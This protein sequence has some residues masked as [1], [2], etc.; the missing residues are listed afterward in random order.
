MIELMLLGAS[1]WDSRALCPGIGLYLYEFRP[2]VSFAHS[3]AHSCAA[4]CFI[5]VVRVDF[6][7]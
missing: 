6:R 1:R 5:H 7:Q 4:F 2:L 3:W